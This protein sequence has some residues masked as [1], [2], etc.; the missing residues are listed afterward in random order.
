[1]INYNAAMNL[2]QYSEK[3]TTQQSILP[4]R[5][6]TELNIEQYHKMLEHKILPSEK[7]YELLQGIIY[8]LMPIGSKHAYLVQVIAER[9]ISCLQ[10][11]AKVYTQSPIQ[12]PP[13]SEPQPDIVVLRP[14]AD[15]YF[16]RLPTSNDVLLW[17]EVS[18]T[19]LQTDRGLKLP[20]C[21]EVGIPEFW[22]VN[23]AQIYLEVHRQP[24][25]TFARYRQTFVFSEN[26]EV[27]PEAFPECKIRWWK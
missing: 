11:A 21:A 22:I 16:D 2:E 3:L 26:E 20:L 8:E 6:W 25:P 4:T 17:I 19:T 27:A 1:M 23:V 24:E 10:G 14:P 18:D 7:R 12:L 5:S 15:Q 9:F 13:N